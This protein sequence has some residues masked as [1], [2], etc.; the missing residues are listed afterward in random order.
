MFLLK[1]NET[2]SVS[3]ENMRPENWG[4]WFNYEMLA[5]E[6]AYAE[7]PWFGSGIDHRANAFSNMPFDL[8]RIGSNEPIA[9]DSNYEEELADMPELNIFRVL[10]NLIADLDLYG[11]AYAVYETNQFG[12]N[13]A[14]RRLHPS[15]INP[16]HNPSTGELLW[17]YRSTVGQQIKIGL[18]DPGFLWL[19]M[20]ERDRENYPGKGVGWRALRAATAIN[21]IDAFQAV[22]FKN[23]AINPTIV[24]MKGFGTQPKDEK[25][26]V[27]NVLQRLM[28]GIANA[29]KIVPLDGDVNVFTL[30]QNLRDMA[31]EVQTTQQRENISTAMQVPQSMLFSN[32]AN[33]ATAQQDDFNFYDKAI[34]P[35][36]NRIV[37][38]QLNERFFR[39]LGYRIEYQKSRLEVYQKLELE[40]SDK[41]VVLLDRG[42]MDVNEIRSQVNLPERTDDFEVPERLVAPDKADTEDTQG[43]AS[44]TNGDEKDTQDKKPRNQGR[45]DSQKSIAG[46][47]LD[48]YAY[49][50]LGDNA[51]IIRIVQRIKNRL[52]DER[53]EWQAAPTYHVTLCYAHL[54]SN[55]VIDQMAKLLRPIEIELIGAYLDV[56]ETPEGKALHLRLESSPSL[57]TL[58][59]HVHEVFSMLPNGGLSEFSNPENY[60]PHITLAYMPNDIPFEAEPMNFRSMASCVIIGRDDYEPALI[61]EAPKRVV[62]DVYG[63]MKTDL[64]KWEQK[65]LKRLAEGKRDK[66][67]EFESQAFAAVQKAAIVGALEIAE[68]VDDVKAIFAE[69]QQTGQLWG[70]YG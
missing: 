63:D 30:M 52:N 68:G 40:N 14:W 25:D 21:A 10:S 22:F 20:P 12:M 19:W 66:M 24:Q 23:G 7:V 39:P 27:Q 54:I 26:R 61:V 35:M 45:Q 4:R 33:F 3:L 13:G 57:S 11:T 42:V 2:K 9:D 67:L 56:F 44:Q 43:D 69:A 34:A 47:A 36:A 28:S 32:A 41:L 55:D 62:L 38:P 46:K 49:I 70:M 29:F 8:M 15:S 31:M 50:P 60:K 18:D 65:A 1:K 17:F 48:A 59:S 58:Q 5:I 64:Q 53:I 16:W 37:K 51:D 6:T